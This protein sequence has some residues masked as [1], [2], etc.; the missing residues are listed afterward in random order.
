MD[1]KDE[2]F[3]ELYRTAIQGL[4]RCKVLIDKHEED[5]EKV[6]EKLLELK[7]KKRKTVYPEPDP[8]QKIKIKSSI[9]RRVDSF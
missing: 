5:I 3:F 9:L 8:P 6:E 4:E 7:G 1:K 2:K